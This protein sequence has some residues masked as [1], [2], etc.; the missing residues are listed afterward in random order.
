MNNKLLIIDGSSML[1]T[2]YYGT[3]PNEIKRC[4]SEDERK[5]FYHLL[6]QTSDGVYTNAIYSMLKTLLKII[7]EQKVTHM[8]ICFDKSR[9]ELI[10]RKIYA[11]Y[12]T[13]R[14]ERPQ[15]LQEQFKH[16]EN[17]LELIGFVVLY[18]DGYEADDYA[19]SLA[20]KFEKQIP[21]YLYTKD[22]DYL[23]LVNKYTKLWLINT[24]QSDTDALFEKYNLNKEQLNLPDKV[25]EYDEEYVIEEFGVYPSQ[26]PDLKGLQ[27]DA[28]DNIPGVYG[29][30]SVAPILLREYRNIEGIYECIN[31]Y[32]GNN[33]LEKELKERWKGIGITRSPL[34][35]LISD[36]DKKTGLSGRES[37]LLS[38]Q[39]ATINR[40][41]NIKQHSLEELKININDYA[42]VDVLNRYEIKS[43]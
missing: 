14:S 37:A 17:I 34:K 35:N 1:S 8:A 36:C 9:E 32:I 28:S 38:R 39:L 11:P 33:K 21:T 43:I 27:G 40:D 5:N 20:K 26:I 4:H 3:L 15:P 2:A 30:S 23:Q 10:R 12:K 16:M 13:N 31:D 18:G 6:L 41:V 22:R 19:G 29:V 7:D 42:L 25:F 24:K